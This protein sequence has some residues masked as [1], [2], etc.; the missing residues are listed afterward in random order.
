MKTSARESHPPRS[1]GLKPQRLDAI[2]FGSRPDLPRA[3]TAVSLCAQQVCTVLMLSGGSSVIMAISAGNCS[4]AN[5]A[6]YRNSPRCR[7]SRVATLCSVAMN[8]TNRALGSQLLRSFQRAAPK[9]SPSS[10]HGLAQKLPDRRHK[11]HD[12]AIPT[13]IVFCSLFEPR[14]RVVH[15]PLARLL[16]LQ[17]LFSFARA[18]E[19][20]DLKQVF[21][22]RI[23]PHEPDVGMRTG[24]LRFGIG[25]S[26]SDAV[27]PFFRSPKVEAATA[28]L[29]LAFS[30]PGL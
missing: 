17:A 1:K 4:G 30:N 23:G 13:H 16:L 6:I 27:Y 14:V 29:E 15:S 10:S 12:D 19:V 11:D 18:T 21:I 22:W 9:D 8:D 24:I 25:S 20:L 28:S 5:E 3:L 7:A 26:C 2:T